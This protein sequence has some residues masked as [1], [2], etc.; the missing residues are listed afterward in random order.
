MWLLRCV[1]FFT[2]NNTGE[3]LYNCSFFEK[4]NYKIGS[5]LFFW[6]CLY[7][8]VL[9]CLFFLFIR[10]AA[11]NGWYGY[12]DFEISIPLFRRNFYHLPK[13]EVKTNKN[14][15]IEKT[16]ILNS[17]TNV[18]PWWPMHFWSFIFALPYICL[19]KMWDNENSARKQQKFNHIQ[20]FSANVSSSSSSHHLDII[21]I[22]VLFLN[23]FYCVRT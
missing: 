14:E 3:N 16:L 6:N 5:Q 2:F 1:F 18:D 10:M 17:K 15:H 4:K 11:R 13:V 19:C 9:F 12:L 8:F 7:C 23:L 21:R 22:V 20:L